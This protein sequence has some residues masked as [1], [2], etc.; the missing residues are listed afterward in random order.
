MH[1]IHIDHAIELSLVLIFNRRSNFHTN[2]ALEVVLR[3]CSQCA[4]LLFL[5]KIG[6]DC[7]RSELAL[8]HLQSEKDLAALIYGDI[9]AL[10]SQISINLPRLIIEQKAV[11]YALPG[12]ICLM[13]LFLHDFH[14]DF[15]LRL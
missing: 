4:K 11:K 14:E 7:F 2:I 13:G 15:K 12:H 8:V 5:L 3:I 1:P 9:S 10:I 6:L